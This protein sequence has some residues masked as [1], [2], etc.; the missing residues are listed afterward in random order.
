MPPQAYDWTKFRIVIFQ[1]SKLDIRQLAATRE[2]RASTRQPS[3]LITHQQLAADFMHEMDPHAGRTGHALVFVSLRDRRALR[4]PDLN[5]RAGSRT[6]ND[7]VSHLPSWLQLPMAKLI[8]RKRTCWRGNMSGSNRAPSDHAAATSLAHN[9]ARPQPAIS[10]RWATNKVSA[11][12]SR[13]PS[14]C[15]QP[16]ALRVFASTR[17]RTWL[18]SRQGQCRCRCRRRAMADRTRC[19]P[20]TSASRLR[21][22]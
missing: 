5:V 22:S 20:T 10:R 19:S 11:V 7:E 8:C 1:N 3:V 2:P 16:S 15:P 21:L 18:C 13:R 17:S 4:H 14:R 9:P 12:V 6:P